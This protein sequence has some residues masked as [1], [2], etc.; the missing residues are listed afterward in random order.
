MDPGHGHPAFADR[1]GAAFDR[2]GADITRRKNPGTL[3]SS[4]PGARIIFCQAGAWATAAPVLMK[5]F[6]SRLISGGNHEVQGL[7]PI[8]ENTAGVST[9]RRSPVALFS[10]T[11]VSSI[12]PP[13]HFADF[14]LVK[15]LDV[16]LRCDAARKVIGHPLAEIISPNEKKHPVRAFGEKHGR[17]SGRI[18]RTGDDDGKPKKFSIK[19]DEPAWPPGA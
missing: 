8:M 1:G 9:V 6:S 2:A 15:N 17:L 7:A 3:V 5:P 10:S 16:R 4:G 14:G 19:E 12:L 18:T 13:R 11:T